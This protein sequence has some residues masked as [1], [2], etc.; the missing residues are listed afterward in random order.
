LAASRRWATVGGYDDPLAWARRVVANRS[1]S[2]IRRRVTE[3]RALVR[4]ASRRQFDDQL[5]LPSD[6]EHVWATIRRLPQRQAQ[7][8]TLRAL[9]GLSL[10]EIGAVLGVSK[11]TAQTHLRRAR[12]KLAAS[13]EGGAT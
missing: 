1:T 4:L 8:I 10:H 12:D 7:A 3:A 13:L 2:V 9:Y 11:E 6:S 5:H